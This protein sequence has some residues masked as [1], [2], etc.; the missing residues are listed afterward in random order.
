MY[1]VVDLLELTSS[2]ID[3]PTEF[4]AEIHTRKYLHQGT[5]IKQIKG[6]PSS[7]KQRHFFLF[8][9]V[10]VYCEERALLVENADGTSRTHTTYQFKGLSYRQSTA[11]D[12]SSATTT[13]NSSADFECF[14]N[15]KPYIITTPSV[16]DKKEW[17]RIL[18]SLYVALNR[19]PS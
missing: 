11:I 3:L 5:V 17:L 19:A 7:A 14:L 10:L 18:Y 8:T 1:S 4:F 9:D 2:I 6:K 12:E 13:D 15:R 16:E